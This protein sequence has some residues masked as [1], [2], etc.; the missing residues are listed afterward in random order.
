MFAG[1][2]GGVTWSA[3]AHSGGATVKATTSAMTHAMSLT[4][5]VTVP[6]MW[7]ALAGVEVEEDALH[8]GNSAAKQSAGSL[9]LRY[10]LSIVRHPTGP[11]P[12]PPHLIG[13]AARADQL[14]FLLGD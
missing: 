1:T 13:A 11:K 3:W 10:M 9:F 7:S 12:R 14:T 8:D 4:R 2:A 6:R 5:R